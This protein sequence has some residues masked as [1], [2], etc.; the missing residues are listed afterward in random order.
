M[1]EIAKEEESLYFIDIR[2]RKLS[3]PLN[4]FSSFNEN[5]KRDVTYDN[6]EIHEKA[7]LH[8]FSRKYI[9]IKTTGERVSLTPPAFLRLDIW[10]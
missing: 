2:R 8:P 4:N 9:F 3:Y 7:G 1:I 5:L 10:T 6:I